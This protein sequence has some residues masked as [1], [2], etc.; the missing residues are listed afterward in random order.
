MGEVAREMQPKVRRVICPSVPA[1][2]PMA[3]TSTSPTTE[4]QVIISNVSS[5]TLAAR[6]A[7]AMDEKDRIAPTIHSAAR[8]SRA[9]LAARRFP[10]QAVAVSS[11]IG[12]P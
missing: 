6:P 4:R 8:P 11:V 3:S 7:M 12:D 10:P 1:I 5:S 2:P 9:G